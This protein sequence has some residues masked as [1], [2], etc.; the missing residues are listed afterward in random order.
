MLRIYGVACSKWI[1]TL[2][3]NSKILEC[4]SR[5]PVLQRPWLMVL[6]RSSTWRVWWPLQ[7][8]C[9]T[10]WP[11]SS[12]TT[13]PTTWCSHRVQSSAMTKWWW[14]VLKMSDNI[15]WRIK[16]CR[17]LS[18]VNLCESIRH[19][20][21]IIWVAWVVSQTALDRSQPVEWADHAKDKW[22]IKSSSRNANLIQWLRKRQKQERAS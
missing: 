17:S 1:T 14:R 18:W 16:A 5:Q 8:I 2:H 7:P 19:K 6:N 11:T 4:R 22:L 20:E 13:T 10:H 3:S 12:S 21:T 9:L 15:C